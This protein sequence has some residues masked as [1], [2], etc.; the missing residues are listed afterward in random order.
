MPSLP[1]VWATQ[2]E[3]TKVG[4]ERDEAPVAKFTWVLVAGSQF[5]TTSTLLNAPELFS[6]KTNKQGESG[7]PT[8]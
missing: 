6:A 5:R 8:T 4:K 7:I 2:R 1:I 3:A